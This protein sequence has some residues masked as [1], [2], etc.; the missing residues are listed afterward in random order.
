M[1]N[2]LGY[3]WI[4]ESKPKIIV[5]GENI[6]GQCLIKADWDTYLNCLKKYI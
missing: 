1:P 3:H 2:S 5:M 4:I 6:K